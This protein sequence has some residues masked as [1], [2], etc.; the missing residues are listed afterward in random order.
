M[1]IRFGEPHDNH[2]P[3]DRVLVTTYHS[4]QDNHGRMTA[5][6]WPDFCHVM[7][8]FT[9]IDVAAV[10]RRYE[11]VLAQSDDRKRKLYGLAKNGTC[12]NA[13]HIEGRRCIANIRRR[14]IAAFDI[15]RQGKTE[16]PTFRAT[17]ER[18]DGLGFAFVAHT[19]FS[20]DP[21]EPRYRVYIRLDRTVEIKDHHQQD[22]A[23]GMQLARELGIEKWID[24]G[25]LGAESLMFLPRAPQGGAT[26]E[27]HVGQGAARAAWDLDAPPLVDRATTTAKGK[28]RKKPIKV[29]D[30]EAAYSGVLLKFKLARAREAMEAWPNDVDYRT[31]I[32][33][34]HALK[35]DLGEDG[36]PLWR[37]W[38]LQWTK[39]DIP[40]IEEKWA[41]FN[42]IGNV[43]LPS[44]FFRA[45][46]G[47][48]DDIEKRVTHSMF[49]NLFRPHFVR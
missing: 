20:H 13:A 14:N 3:D 29:Y 8:H 24:T 49:R 46:R 47:G 37:D 17:C 48:W 33:T 4:V 42:P 21:A 34:G 43:R 2:Q 35:Y 9:F 5:L 10:E 12:I 23:A 27:W 7:T 45:C 15:E 26:P 16:P 19:S 11:Q 28:P 31:W 30:G 39:N 18:I 6:T 32:S 25:K 1:P 40:T 38:S 41:S 22:R 44:V 36:Y